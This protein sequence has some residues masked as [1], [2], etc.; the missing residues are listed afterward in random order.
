MSSNEKNANKI[1]IPS[2]KEC[3]GYINFTINPFNFS[4]EYKCEK[5]DSH[6]K[7]H[8][9]FKTFERFYLKE[10]DLLTCSKCRLSLENSQYINCEI[11][12]QIY[13]VNCYI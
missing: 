11:C 10:K 5:N 6:N 2:C 8:I 13:C 7:R 9:Y 4:V 3:N 12:K 1:F